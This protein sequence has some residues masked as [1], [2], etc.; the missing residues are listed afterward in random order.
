MNKLKLIF[1]IVAIFLF[2][3]GCSW[4]NSEL[5]T[6]Y[7][8]FNGK[9][10]I[11]TNGGDVQIYDPERNI[12]NRL[13]KLEGERVT[14]VF[15]NNRQLIIETT[16][17]LE[18]KLINNFR[19]NTLERVYLLS[20]NNNLIPL[21]D[22]LTPG[23]KQY[24]SSLRAAD[25][26]YIY[27]YK[28]EPTSG[29]RNWTLEKSFR[30]DLNTK[31]IL[32]SNFDFNPDYLVEDI[33][34]DENYFWYI[35]LYDAEGLFWETNRGKSV[36]LRREKK[37]NEISEI[38][39]TDSV[40]EGRVYIVGDNQNIWVSGRTSNESFKCFLYKISKKDL[41]YKSTS[42][43]DKIY[44][45]D[46]N[47]LWSTISGKN[48]TFFG[49]NDLVKTTFNLEVAP[50][51]SYNNYPSVSIGTDVYGATFHHTKRGLFGSGYNPSI[52]K[53]SAINHSYE[54]IPLKTTLG[55]GLSNLGSSVVGNIT[56]FGL[57][58]LSM[59]GG[60]K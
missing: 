22:T 30:I 24:S 4:K 25:D 38:F 16:E 23:S 57:I 54:E 11:G 27:G 6:D 43:H 49:K 12:F 21:C 40:F 44:H 35:C 58:F 17:V 55:D 56:T 46:D 13:R 7:S 5:I 48:I 36:V 59:L 10:Y 53:V 32:N 52:I 29:A 20:T 9:L 26:Q 45:V 39:L 42:F 28:N 33:Y 47:Y 14:R 8:K 19:L 3:N 51:D 34:E 15:S 60:G 18:N 2:A 37:T 31:T 41:T 50:H 1:F